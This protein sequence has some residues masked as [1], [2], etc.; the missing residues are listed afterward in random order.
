MD[1]GNTCIIIYILAWLTFVYIQI[2]HIKTVGP[3]TMVMISYSIYAALCYFYYNSE[4]KAENP[5]T[6]LT[7]IPFIY[8]FIMLCLA[9]MPGI[10]F[11]RSSVE[12]IQ[13][14]HSYIVNSFIII[15]CICSIIQIPAI[16]DQI[17]SGITMILLDSQGGADLY[18]EKS[19]RVLSVSDNSI[20]GI[21]GLISIVHNVFQDVS[22]FFVFYYLTF[23]KRKKI[24]L[25]LLTTIVIID[26]LSSLAQGERNYIMM[27]FFM[28]AVGYF[29]F[30]NFMEKKIRSFVKYLA[31]IM[32]GLLLIPFAAI[33][34]SRFGNSKN[35]TPLG[36][37]ISYAGKAPV[38]FNVYVY[39]T[40]DIRYG[41]RTMNLFKK[42]L[43]YKVPANHEEGHDKYPNLIIDDYTFYTFVGDFVMDFGVI[44]AA[45]LFF[46]FSVIF[47]SL[48]RARHGTIKLHQM[49]L[50]FFV[51]NVCA[52]GGMYLFSYSYNGN[53]KILGYFFMYFILLIDT[54]S[55]PVNRRTYLVRKV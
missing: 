45:L 47:V 5:Y 28:F 24:L 46:A 32:M 2:R 23:T 29:L 20:S 16:L 6:T 17:I 38:N 22:V 3:A 30:N 42:M 26:V 4:F 19:N 27:F 11:E 53:W 14:P 10:C 52:Q 18:L 8:L 40:N 31:L 49:L 55:I 15:Y 41:D 51:L 33:T 43:G 50:I 1:W 34:I 9:L 21:S 13:K 44:V 25:L 35:T 54:R 48:T 7:L 39:H 36:S 37:A 12:Y